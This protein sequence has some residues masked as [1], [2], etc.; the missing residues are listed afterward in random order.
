MAT[1]LY[2]SINLSFVVRNAPRVFMSASEWND[3]CI[4]WDFCVSGRS[5]YRVQVLRLMQN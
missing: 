5:Q 1:V 3:L 4:L 2:Q